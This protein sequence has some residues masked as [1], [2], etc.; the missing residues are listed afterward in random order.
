MQLVG[1]ASLGNVL[2]DGIAEAGNHHIVRVLVPAAS[3]DVLPAGVQIDGHEQE[4][5]IHLLAVLLEN[6]AQ[7]SGEEVRHVL[8]PRRDL[9]VGED[10]E[11]V[12]HFPLADE[13]LHVIERK[14]AP[15]TE[16][17]RV[18]QLGDDLHVIQHCA[19]L[20]LDLQ[21]ALLPS[22]WRREDPKVAF[23]A[24]VLAHQAQQGPN[25]QKGP[26]AAQTLGIL[27]HTASHRVGYAAKHY[28]TPAYGFHVV[29]GSKL[30]RGIEGVP[31]LLDEGFIGH[32][33]GDDDLLH[34]ALLRLLG[35]GSPATSATS[36][37]PR[38]ATSR[39]LGCYF[40]L[41]GLSRL[42]SS[43]LGNLD[44]L[45][46]LFQIDVNRF[47]C[48]KEGEGE[49]SAVGN[50]AFVGQLVHSPAMVLV[51]DTGEDEVTQ[52]PQ[53]RHEGQLLVID[54]FLPGFGL[55]AFRRKEGLPC[56][57][58]RELQTLSCTHRFEGSW[59]TATTK[60]GFVRRVLLAQHTHHVFHWGV[61]V[62]LTNHLLHG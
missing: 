22:A 21:V 45:L 2:Q 26:H 17:T 20:Q 48:G 3:V 10:D 6:T 36:A 1:I 7:A 57:R 53:H 39:R 58:H 59:E 37:T 32:V 11:V 49:L 60:I 30:H 62:Q 15:A 29:H 41:D 40:R 44:L 35:R 18:R 23:L 42:T 9:G 43:S 52:V 54:K 47:V 56:L 12:D 16:L 38:L 27:R 33:L 50:S 14:L 31:V 5:R 19:V 34:P 51:I 24:H 55:V 4:V 61:D 46:Q 28:G 8:V 13:V 25:I